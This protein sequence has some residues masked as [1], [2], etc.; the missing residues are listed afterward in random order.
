MQK[1][2]LVITRHRPL[3]ELLRERGIIDDTTPVLEHATISDVAG[4]HVLGILPHHLSSRCASITEIPMALTQADREAM[5]R[6]DLSLER[7]REV[8]GDPVTYYVSTER[9]WPCVAV[10]ARACRHAAPWSTF[11]ARSIGPGVLELESA[12][13]LDHAHVDLY[14]DRYRT[15][16]M[17]GKWSPWFDE[18][19]ELHP[20]QDEPRSYSTEG[21]RLVALSLL[22]C[23][24]AFEP[25]V[26]ALRSLGA[27]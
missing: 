18:N 3:V 10:F 21:R 15:L 6:G 19:G 9:T 7:T 14:G 24:L 16:S 23:D 22:E 26:Q 4:K 5:T 27:T 13:G 20:V 12:E 8:A 11:H 25:V 1:I 2:D 17:G